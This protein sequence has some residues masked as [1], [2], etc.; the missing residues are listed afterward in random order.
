MMINDSALEK[1]LS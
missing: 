1:G